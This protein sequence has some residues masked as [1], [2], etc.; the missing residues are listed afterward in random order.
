ME[1]SRFGFKAEDYKRRSTTTFWFGIRDKVGGRLCTANFWLRRSWVRVEKLLGRVQR[2]WVIG[3]EG[4][5]SK[6]EYV[7]M[8]GFTGSHFVALQN[9]QSIGPNFFSFLG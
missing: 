1:F 8:M 7:G 6:G 3:A 5:K 2:N 9:A 4:N